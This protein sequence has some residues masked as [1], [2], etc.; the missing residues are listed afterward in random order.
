M[1]R[2]YRALAALSF[3]TLIHS[4]ERPP[5]YVNQKPI[6][7]VMASQTEGN[8]PLSVDFDASLSSD[9]EDGSLAYSWDFGNGTSSTSITPSKTFNETG[10]YTVTLT[11]T[12]EGGLQDTD[13][14]TIKVNEP[15]NLFP[16]SE[17][18]QWVYLVKSTETENGS[19]SGYAEG[20]TYITVKDINLEYDNIE[21]I[22]LRV[23]GKK[24]YNGNL[25]GDYIFLSHVAGRSLGV[26]HDV[27]ET[28]NNMIDLESQS[29]NN[30]AMFF[31]GS[32]SQSVTMT[33]SNITIGLGTFQAFRVKHQR[34][35]WGEQY[36][37]ERYD[38]SEEEWLDPEIGLI[39]RKTSRYVNFLDCF[40]CPVYGGSNEI[41]LVGYYIPQPDGSVSQAGYGYNPDNPYGGNLGVLT[42][43][44]SVDIGYTEVKLDGEY[45]GTIS[46]YWPDGLTCD[47]PRALNVSKPD[48][49]YLLTAESSNGYYWEGTIYFTEGTCDTIELLLTKKGTGGSQ[50]IRQS[51]R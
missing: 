10:T 34:D 1:N 46:N 44:A 20:L 32:S 30:Y 3:L 27:G 42:I 49:G 12:D 31:S 22:D 37:S 13:Q 25:L 21:F 28:F 6:A 45:V 47:Q 14:A 18:S 9:P 50:G 17:N 38:I 51:S 33:T 4:C 26:K 40:Y 5:E 41:E 7:K 2:I 16:L 48:G 15:P 36:V 19:V 29:W 8:R 23:T 43:W 24:Y 35:N 11:V 39:Y